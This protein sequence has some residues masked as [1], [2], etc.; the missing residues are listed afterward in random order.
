MYMMESDV[1]FAN[2]TMQKASEC[3]IDDDLRSDSE[4]SSRNISETGIHINL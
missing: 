2:P 1:D 3:L 4:K